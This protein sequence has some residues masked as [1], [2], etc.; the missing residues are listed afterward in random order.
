M[1]IGAAFPSKYIKA[2]DLGGKEFTLQIATVKIEDVGGQNNEE[3]RPVLYFVGRQ[4]GVVLNRTNATA[5][6]HRYGD[7]TDE[8]ANKEVIIYPDTTMFQG[9]MVD[10]IRMRVPAQPADPNDSSGLPF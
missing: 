10:C 4:K 9:K 6:A 3:D 1:K 7:D 8:W 2:A 5:I